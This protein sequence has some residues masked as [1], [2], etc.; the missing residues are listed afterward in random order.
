MEKSLDKTPEKLTHKEEKRRQE[1]GKKET[2]SKNEVPGEQAV[3]RSKQKNQKMR[4][5]IRH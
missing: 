4:K 1:Y 2:N 3:H 5:A